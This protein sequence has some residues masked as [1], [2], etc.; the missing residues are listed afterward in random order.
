MFNP[1]SLFTLQKLKYQLEIDKDILSPYIE[2]EE[3]LKRAKSK[4]PTS[5]I[6]TVSGFSSWVYNLY[7][8]TNSA[9]LRVGKDIEK[10]IELS[11]KNWIKKLPKRYNNLD[12]YSGFRLIFADPLDGSISPLS[13]S[14]LSVSGERLRGLPDLVLEHNSGKARNITI[15]ERKVTKTDRNRIHAFGWPNLEVQLWC[16]GWMDEWCEANEVFL[17]GQIWWTNGV[18]FVEINDIVPRWQRSE[19]DFHN[20][21]LELFE[22][23]GGKW[24]I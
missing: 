16:Y 24:I 13:S 5:P 9:S 22:I 20:R 21:C 7:N 10:K 18:N 14:K 11:R 6:P 15:I 17:I 2:P 1:K 8:T 3:I 23:Y 12:A 19:S 4:V